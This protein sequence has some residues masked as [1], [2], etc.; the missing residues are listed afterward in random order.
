MCQILPKSPP[1]WSLRKV[2][3]WPLCRIGIICACAPNLAKI[4]FIGDR[5]VRDIAE[6]QNSRCRPPP[7]WIS[8]KCYFGSLVAVVYSQYE[9]VHQIRCKSANSWPRY[10]CL[11]IFKMVAATVLNFIES[12]ILGHTGSNPHVASEYRPNKF[13]TNIFIGDRV[14]AEEQNTRWRPPPSCIFN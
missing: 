14:M 7:F 13:A 10:T 8:N 2:W 11:C 3:F 5:E 12:W 4:I 1:S 9:A 6:K